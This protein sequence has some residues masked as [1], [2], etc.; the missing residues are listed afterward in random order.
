MPSMS[1][2]PEEAEQ[3]A[4]YLVRQLGPAKAGE[5][6]D[7][8]V[9]AARVER[10]RAAFSARGCATCH[11]IGHNQREV[12]VGL[13]GRPLAQGRPGT[14]SRSPRTAP[15]ARTCV[16]MLGT[17][18]PNADPDRSGPAVAIVVRGSVYLVDAGPGIVR[19]AA[20]AARVD[21]IPELGAVNLRRVFLTH[22]HS[23]HTI[24][25]PDLIFSPWVA[26]RTAA[27]DV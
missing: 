14:T 27:L 4:M 2:S 26:G 5:G 20:L 19:R 11:E 15:P 1:L 22:L 23:D 3:V 21:S 8:V 18:N 17:G 9:D 7:F 24:G 10:G 6:W 25:L 12:K 13:T 16:V